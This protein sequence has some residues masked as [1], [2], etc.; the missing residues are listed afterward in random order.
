MLRSLRPLGL[1]VERE[2]RMADGHEETVLLHAAKT[3]IGAGSGQVD[4]PEE[5]AFGGKTVDAVIALATPA[6][7]GPEIAFRVGAN[8]IGVSGGRCDEDAVVF[9]PA[10]VD[11]IEN[12]NVLWGAGVD[13]VEAWTSGVP[14]DRLADGWSE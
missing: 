6:G 12:T 2:K 3:D 10:A 7:A 5:I 8:A 1:H 14:C 4:F 11:D 13:D 9:Q